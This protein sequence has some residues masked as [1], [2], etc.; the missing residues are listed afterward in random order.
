MRARKLLAGLAVLALVGTA[1]NGGT[2]TPEQK[3][4]FSIKIG[5]LLPLTGFLTDFGPAMERAAELAVEYF[6]DAATAADQDITVELLIEDSQTDPTAGVEGANK[7]SADGVVA[8][9][10]GAASSVTIAVAESVTIPNQILQI[11]PASTSGVI[12]DLEDD[13][14]VNRVPPSD[15][16]Q[17][18]IL[19]AAIV[20]AFGD[21][22]TI[23]IGAR[24]DAYGQ[25]I[26]EQVAIELGKLGAETS[27]PVLW[28]PEG[29][30]TYNSEAGR[31]VA[32]NPDGWVLVDFPGT[33]KK[34]S[35]ALVRTDAWDPARTFSADGLKT[36]NLPQDP[37]LG[38]SCEASE[39]MRGTAPGGTEFFDQLWE[40]RVGDEIA[41]GAFDAHT[42]DGVMLSLLSA[43]AA[44][45][46][47]GALMRD[48]LQAVS[49]PGGTQYGIENLSE[50]I[51]ALVNGEDID[52]EG[53]AGPINLD[54]NGD[55]QSE[56][57][58]YDLWEITD[59][60]MTTVRVERVEA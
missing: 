27:D 60:T 2:T 17:A 32:G 36:P 25:Y 46:A 6:E 19:A 42:F 41:R 54:E 4:S 18:P 26:T 1:C 30:G 34:V 13:G 47:D 53:A 33:W 35:A 38:S 15:E 20:D 40:D 58:F 28:N 44:G 45:E 8:I 3:V 55:P 31:I 23:N 16:H 37:P 24:D 21:D 7:L 57:A 9:V 22:A 56:G 29:R 10:G 50:A 49:G 39:G 14:F 12:T 48:E 52:Y 11:S 59:C 43:V 5:A 51:T